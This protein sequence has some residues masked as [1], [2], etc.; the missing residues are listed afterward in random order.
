[1]IVNRQLTN[2]AALTAHKATPPRLHWPQL[3]SY[4]MSACRAVRML[5]RRQLSPLCAPL[6]QP[7]PPSC[8]PSHPCQLAAF[9]PSSSK[10]QDLQ[11]K[12]IAYPPP[13]PLPLHSLHSLSLLS[14][15]DWN[16]CLGKILRAVW[17]NNKAVNTNSRPRLASLFQMWRRRALFCAA[18]THEPGCNPGRCHRCPP[19]RPSISWAPPHPTAWSC[20]VFAQRVCVHWQ[21]VCVRKLPQAAIGTKCAFEPRPRE[22]KNKTPFKR[23]N[24]EPRVTPGSGCSAAACARITGKGFQ[25]FF[26]SPELPRPLHSSD[27]LKV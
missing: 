13:T 18:P 22:G 24:Q 25:T 10:G 3:N 23:L 7:L 19:H 27:E 8:R 2:R 14:W 16:V 21:C 11:W 26:V 4:S 1:M 20:T 17:K 15:R 12:N 5:T 6:L 9:E